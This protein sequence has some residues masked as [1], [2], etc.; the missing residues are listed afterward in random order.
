MRRTTLLA[1]ACS[2]WIACGDDTGPGGSGGS[3]AAG[4]GGASGGGG[5]TAN[6]GA[7]PGGAPAGG[8]GASSGGG[9]EGGLAQGGGGAGTGGGAQAAPECT[10][11]ADCYLSNDCCECAGRPVGQL[12][13]DCA[14]QCLQDTCP[15]LGI[16]GEA[17][18]VAGRCV[19]PAS[20]DESTVLCDIPTPQCPMGQL[21]IVDGDC[22]AGGCLPALE[23][24]EVTSC[25]S[26]SALTGATCV[27]NV[28]QLQSFHCVDRASP[29]SEAS[30]DC[31]GPSVCI[32]PFD[33][34]S[35]TAD[36]LD[37]SCPVCSFGP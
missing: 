15:A 2:L 16:D 5:S 26:C 9:G 31:L 20:C 6:G 12:A 23:C 17:R 29:C 19:A 1:L 11:D 25:A 36:G 4:A 8:G 13:P 18:C 37:C 28:T 30:C 21:P 10:E 27:H 33:A 32:E 7:G 14:Q 22:Y 3:G 34:C 35:E 24:E